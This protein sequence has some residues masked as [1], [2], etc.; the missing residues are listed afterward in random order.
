[1]RLLIIIPAFNEASTLTNVI[2]RLPQKLT[3]I[4]KIDIVVIDDGST[5]KTSEIAATKKVYLVKHKINRGLGAT[6]GTGFEFAKKHDYDIIVTFDADGQHSASDVPKLISP[7]LH[8]KADVVIGSR[9]HKG[10]GMPYLRKII[11]IGSNIFTFLLFNI[12]TTDSQSGLRA[13]SMNV[14]RKMRIRSQGMEVSSEIFKE[15]SRLK[16]RLVEVPIR[17]IYT[18]YSLE[19]GQSLTNAPNVIWKLLLNRFG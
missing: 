9:L 11:N 16:L 7:L 10:V 13:F 18:H 12:W 8:N 15:I 2:D 1:M 19:K 5:D 17:S 3:N 4:S 14:I 6:L